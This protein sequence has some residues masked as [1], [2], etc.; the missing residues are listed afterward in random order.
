MRSRVRALMAVGVLALVPAIA[1]AAAPARQDKA[2]AKSS[3]AKPATH[4]TTGVVK[5]ITDSA[6]VLSHPGKHS[7][8]MTFDLNSATQ[9]EGTI[10]TGAQVSVRYRDEGS[11]HVATAV[12]AQHGKHAAH[13]AKPTK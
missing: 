3:Q 4:S 8:D 9:R 11:N 10:D 2:A 5:S 1:G 13:A 6:L 7:A 12:M